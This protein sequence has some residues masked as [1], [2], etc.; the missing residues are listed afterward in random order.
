MKNLKFS[1]E[2]TNK[3]KNNWLT[4]ENKEEFK[5]CK[6][7]SDWCL[8]FARVSNMTELEQGLQMDIVNTTIKQLSNK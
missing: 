4:I 8:T 6:T 3:V 5:Q 1:T 7:N 2:L